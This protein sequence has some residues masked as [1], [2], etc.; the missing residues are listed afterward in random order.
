NLIARAATEN[1]PMLMVSNDTYQTAKK[2]DGIVP[3]LTTKEMF[4]IDILTDLVQQNVDIKSII[5]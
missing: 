1:I 2:I 4:K 5:S 3:L